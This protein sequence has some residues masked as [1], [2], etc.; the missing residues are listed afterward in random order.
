MDYRTLE[1]LN[2]FQELIADIRTEIIDVK[3]ELSDINT[4]LD[5]ILNHVCINS[6][7]M[8][9]VDSVINDLKSSTD[10]MNTHIDFV[11]GV[12]EHVKNPLSLVLGRKLQ[13]SSQGVITYIE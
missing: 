2:R 7:K 3:R 6:E 8:G 10:K 1:I 9:N 5:V 13:S 11:N 4:R 12:Y